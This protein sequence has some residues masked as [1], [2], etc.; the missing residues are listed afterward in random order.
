[1]KPVQLSWITAAMLG[2]STM[3]HAGFDGASSDNTV[4]QVGVSEV[5]VPFFH[6][7]GK[8][9]IGKAGG[10]RVDFQSL[11]NRASGIFGTTRNGIHTSGNYH[12]SNTHYNFAKAANQDVWFGEWY[13]G[14][15]DTGF[16]NRVVY[17]VGDDTG[18]TVPTSG[19]ATYSVAGINKFSGSNKLNGTFTANFGT[20]TLTGNIANS[21]LSVGVNASINASTAAFTGSAT[22]SVN[23]G[24]ATN[25]ASQGHFFGAN[26][27][28]LAGIATFTNSDLDTAFGGSKN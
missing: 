16:N 14:D 12:F 24:A 28:A 5:Y 17:Y 1:M 13:E 19:V 25:G 21:S 11:A 8:A 20:Q 7:K 15:Q 4:R 23:G 27:S 2:L 18:T 3:A 6:Q 10:K 26:A 9:G 22:A